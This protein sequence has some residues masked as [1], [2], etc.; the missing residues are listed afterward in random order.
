[1]KHRSEEDWKEGFEQAADL[2]INE[3]KKQPSDEIIAEIRKLNNPYDPKWV[4]MWSIL[5][6]R[7]ERAIGFK[8]INILESYDNAAS[9]IKREHC[10]QAIFKILEIN[11]FALS[12]LI[13][14]PTND[15]NLNYF[16][17]GIKLLKKYSS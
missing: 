14:G 4:A 8:L 16:K 10:V 7:K 17:L 12:I 11:D 2:Y 6:E 1:M 5:G 3:I 13:T 15:F 9:F